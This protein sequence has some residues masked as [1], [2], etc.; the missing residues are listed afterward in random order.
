M[1]AQQTSIGYS[2]RSMMQS[3]YSGNITILIDAKYWGQAFIT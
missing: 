2:P 3:G 1:P